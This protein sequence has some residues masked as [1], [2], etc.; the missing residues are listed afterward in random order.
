M[1]V[2]NEAVDCISEYDGF[3]CT[4]FSSI[5]YG[6]DHERM[7]VLSQ[8]T[9]FYNRMR[10]DIAA[11]MDE[12]DFSILRASAKR[13]SAT[14]GKHQTSHRFQLT[15]VDDYMR[16]TLTKPGKKEKKKLAPK[17]VTPSRLFTPR[18]EPPAVPAVKKS[19]ST[20]SIA[21]PSIKPKKINWIRVEDIADIPEGLTFAPL[22]NH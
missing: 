7:S 21:T 4:E 5:A 6:K 13:Q 12:V 20:S 10:L 17:P 9:S 3:G 18:K 8:G 2:Q 16:T 11:I 22:S 19:S 1:E 15:T 14:L